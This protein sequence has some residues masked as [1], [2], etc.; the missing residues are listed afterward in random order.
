MI[1]VTAEALAA[2]EEK[3]RILK[4]ALIKVSVALDAERAKAK[5]T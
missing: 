5:A 3:A 2:R 1:G 4:K